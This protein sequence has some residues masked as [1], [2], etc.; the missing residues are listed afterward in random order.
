MVILPPGCI[1]HCT[2]THLK[3]GIGTQPLPIIEHSDRRRLSSR[4]GMLVNDLFIVSPRS[5]P[6]KYSQLILDTLSPRLTCDEV[7]GRW[8]GAGMVWISGVLEHNEVI[9]EHVHLHIKLVSR[10]THNDKEDPL[11]SVFAPGLDSPVPEADGW[12]WMQFTHEQGRKGKKTIFPPYFA[13]V[14]PLQSTYRWY[15]VIH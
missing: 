14:T 11:T 9:T 5:H 7:Y 1:I 13:A 10:I 4:R 3:P 8:F 6:Q 12:M 15:S 2:Y